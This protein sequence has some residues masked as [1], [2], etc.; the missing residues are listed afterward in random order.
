MLEKIEEVL[1]QKVRP[2]LRSHFGDI[3][4]VKLEGTTLFVKLVGQC[5]N[6]VSSKITFE[7]IVEKELLN[8]VPEITSVRLE[9][10][11]SEELINIAKKILNKGI[12]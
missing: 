10:G 2:T 3:E 1:D 12:K 6:C 7:E 4:I 8:N 5:S 9:D 11:I